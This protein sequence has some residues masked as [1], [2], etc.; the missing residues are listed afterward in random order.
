MQNVADP[1]G[2]AAIHLNS[3]Q[4]SKLSPGK[5]IYKGDINVN[6]PSFV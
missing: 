1:A 4:N 5:E 2:L 6:Q 3:H